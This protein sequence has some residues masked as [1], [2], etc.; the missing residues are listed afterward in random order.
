MTTGRVKDSCF[1]ML[2]C[3]SESV[4]EAAFSLGFE[5]SWCVWLLLWNLSSLSLSFDLEQRERCENERRN[6]GMTSFFAG[7]P[8]DDGEQAKGE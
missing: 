2:R 5:E 1:A 6:E 3:L 4:L 8:R 7:H